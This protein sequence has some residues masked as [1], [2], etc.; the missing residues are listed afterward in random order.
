MFHASVQS[1]VINELGNFFLDLGLRF[2]LDSLAML[3]FLR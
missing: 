3:Q 1:K 2:E